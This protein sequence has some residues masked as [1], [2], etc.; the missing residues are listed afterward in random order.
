MTRKSL[1]D[2]RSSVSG[3]ALRRTHS[4]E[5]HEDRCEPERVVETTRARSPLHGETGSE[6]RAGD[7]QPMTTIQQQTNP[8][9]IA[10]ESELKSAIASCER[11]GI[12]YR[13]YL[14]R[15]LKLRRDIEWTR[16]VTERRIAQGAP[17]A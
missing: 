5:T 2:S 11:A 13:R 17:R 1:N 4:E 10:L 6:T 9:E 12:A 3:T 15:L 7:A 8:N 14:D 16:Q